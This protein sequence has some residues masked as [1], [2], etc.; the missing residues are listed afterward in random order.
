MINNKM[1]FSASMLEFFLV[2]QFETPLIPIEKVAEEYFGI[3]AVRSIQN[4]VKS[5]EFEN[6]GLSITTIS[7]NKHF[8]MVED[9]AKFILKS[10]KA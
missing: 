8:V 4:K 3:S 10:R 7:K 5:G 9:L 2:E 1:K 6:L